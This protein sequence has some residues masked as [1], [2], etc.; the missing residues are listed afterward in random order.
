MYNNVNQSNK[1]NLPLQCPFYPN[2][3]FIDTAATDHYAQLSAPLHNIS[4]ITNPQP[5]NLTNGSE[6]IASY[7]GILPNLPTITTINKTAQV[8]PDNNN[9]SLIS[10]GKL[11][12]D[13]YEAS[14]NSEKCVVHKNNQ[15]ILTAPRCD[16]TGMYVINLN[17]PRNHQ[18][19]QQHLLNAIP[20]NQKFKTANIQ[21]FI[22]LER[23]SF[24]HGSLGGPK[25][26][27]LRQAVKAG[28]LQSWP[29]LTLE[30][31][32]KL[33]ESYATILGH[34]DHVRKNIQ[35]TKQQVPFVEDK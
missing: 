17:Q 34:L 19:H 3:A 11:C 16:K 15:E 7:K 28:Y 33:K 26:K 27:T 5:I 21:D 2:N 24:L 12:D 22:S 20:S 8:Y 18:Y 9:I 30:T 6:I 13:G 1:Q 23:T 32:M 4:P 14:I 31:L 10:L 29:G 25:L 35:S